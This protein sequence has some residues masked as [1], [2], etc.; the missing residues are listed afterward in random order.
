MVLIPEYIIPVMICIVILTLVSNAY[1]STTLLSPLKQI[2]SGVSLYDVKC[3]DGLELVVKASNNTPACVKPHTVWKLSG[4]GWLQRYD[5]NS[6]NSYDVCAGCG[7][8]AKASCG[9]G[10]TLLNGGYSMDAGI[11]II[12]TDKRKMLESDGSQGLEFQLLN[13]YNETWR[14]YVWVNCK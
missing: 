12:S 13:K 8:I 6:G 10:H 1:A 5:N 14:V 9:I 4:I 7:V 11:P 3:K 2:K